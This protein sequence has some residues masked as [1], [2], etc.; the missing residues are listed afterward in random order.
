MTKAY[1]NFKSCKLYHSK[2]LFVVAA[3]KDLANVF[4]VS[5]IQYPWTT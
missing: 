5:Q 2:R 1:A 3:P 4:T